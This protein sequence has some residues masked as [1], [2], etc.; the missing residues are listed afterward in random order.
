MP[1]E[2]TTAWWP[3]TRSHAPDAGRICAGDSST[4]KRSP[5]QIAREAIELVSL[6]YAVEKQAKNISAAERLALRQQQSAPVL[7]EIHEKLFS[8]RG[9][10]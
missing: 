5:P 8:G 9:S 10:C 3:A 1:M 7:A 4:L 2:G 6:L